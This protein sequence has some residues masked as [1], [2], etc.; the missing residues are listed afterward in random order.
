M[1]FRWSPVRLPGANKGIRPSRPAWYIKMGRKRNLFLPISYFG[2]PMRG[3]YMPGAFREGLKEVVCSTAVLC[4]RHMIGELSSNGRIGL[5]AV[6]LS[7]RRMQ[8]DCWKQCKKESKHND[9]LVHGKILLFPW[10]TLHRRRGEWWCSP[11]PARG[12]NLNS[13]YSEIGSD[14]LCPL[15]RTCQL[16]SYWI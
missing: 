5:Y 13:C 4:V 6:F 10:I 1:G 3:L 11:L 9:W 7:H 16:P 8:N 12:M 14:T 15:Q 2:L